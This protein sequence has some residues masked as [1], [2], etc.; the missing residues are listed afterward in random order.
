MNMT[1]EK[2]K[3]YQKAAAAAKAG[4]LGVPRQGRLLP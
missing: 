3:F 1:P 4:R 2:V